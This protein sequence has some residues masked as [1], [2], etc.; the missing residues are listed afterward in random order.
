M[1]EKLTI[2]DIARLAGVSKA[3][4]S[5]VL[6]N[7]PSVDPTLAQRVMGIV[8]EHN[9]VPNVTATG[10]ARGRSRLIGVLAPPLTWPSVAEIMH[11][12]AEYLES[13]SY[14]IVLYSIGFER[15]HSDVLDHILSMRM[16]AGLLAIFPGE[17]SHHLTERFQQGLPLVII[18]DQEEP[19][20]LPWVGI[21]NVASAYEATSH[22]LKAG[23]RRIAHILGPQNYYCAVERYQ[24]YREALHDAGIAVDPALL[25]HGAFEPASGRQCATELF[26]LEKSKWPTALFVANDQMAYGVLEVAE[27]RGIH[28]PEEM[29]IVGFDDNS[30]SAHVRPALTT[31]RQ[32]FSEMGRKACE[33]LV[34]QI[35]ADHRATPQEP[36]HAL[37]AFPAADIRIQL[38][39]HLIVRAS[40][41]VSQSLPI[42][43]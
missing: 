12:I 40:S 34:T 10:L 27:Q 28:I 14:E 25:F 16:V 26:S 7:N 33:V 13:T 43:L 17:L 29:A 30:L 19:A 11:G 36:E 39:T 21:D 20:T 32:P 1:Q 4:V 15:N 8:R 31:I 22:L 24:G 38:P 42:G 37:E 9:F 35:D 5:R 2:Q 3:T 6:N 23:H 41:G 18:D